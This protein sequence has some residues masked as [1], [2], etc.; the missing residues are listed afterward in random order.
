M[1]YR[2][3]ILMVLLAGLVQ[4]QEMEFQVELM[5]RVGTETSRKGDL[6]TARILAPAAFQGSTVEGKITESIPGAKSRGKSVLVFEFDML[7]HGGTVTPIQSRIETAVNSA[8]ASA[9]PSR[10]TSGLGRTL[11]GLT[12]GRGA[13]VGGAVDATATAAGRTSSDAP[14]LRFEPGTKFVLKAS[15][16]SGPALA[17]LASAPA[18]VA[19]S[20]APAQVKAAPAAAAAAAPA[21]SGQLELTAVKADFIPGDKAVFFDDFT[22]M[23]GDDAPPH[24]KVR[25]GT[26]ELR[27]GEG[28]RQLSMTA[29]SVTLT[30]NLKGLPKNFTMESVMK[31]QGHGVAV[32]WIFRGKT[33]QEIMRMQLG[34]VYTKMD[35]HFRVG[36]EIIS[37]QQIV[38]DWTKPVRQALWLQK[39]RLRL[40]LNGERAFDANQIEIE[41]IATVEAEVSM[42]QDPRPPE[43]YFGF[44]GVRFAESFPDMSQVITSTGRYIVRGILFDTDSDGIKPESAPAIKKIATSLEANPTL[45]LT[46]EGHTDSVGDAAHNLDL[47]K[48]RAEAVRAVLVG[49]FNV[50]A[51]RLSAAGLG[52]TKPVE[53]NDTPQGRAQNRRVELVRQ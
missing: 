21:S 26:A 35:I 8:A 13:R 39:G 29:R 53:P 47:S 19:A 28:V 44:Q 16:R 38:M 22:D 25:G 3:A 15:A 30:P 52:A 51:G 27:T 41:E 5:N 18:T 48:R 43:K 46:I 31:Y 32:H 14:N 2:S 42:S 40:Y 9:P 6:V 36:K 23:N 17:S 1:K 34:S 45:K 10:G 11:G 33:G 50:D 7:R 37:S 49:Q 24:W 20:P 12:G 4:A